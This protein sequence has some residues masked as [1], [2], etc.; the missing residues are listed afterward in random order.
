MKR[1]YTL[2][3]LSLLLMVSCNIHAQSLE[4]KVIA[5]GGASVTSPLQVD[6]TIGEMAVETAKISNTIILTQGFQQPY[7]V[8]IPNN[9]IFPY[10]I[11]YPNPA[12]GNALARFVLAAPAKMT[13]SI[14]DA[15]GQL[16]SSEQVNYTNGEMQYIIKSTGWS[17]GTY[18]IRFAL[19]DGSSVGKQLIK[20][21]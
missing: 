3:W 1:I 12:A 21:Q 8:V 13:I 19:Q 9:N 15:T 6:Y 18:F 17:Q 10:L 5:S 16:M 20:L 14:Y 7:Y 11:I 2:T 4:R